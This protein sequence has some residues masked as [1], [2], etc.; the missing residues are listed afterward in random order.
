M[1]NDHKLKQDVL[2]ELAWE[3]SIS[4]DHIG[5]TAK[6]GVITLSGYVDNFW[7]KRSAEEA[8]G[9]V[10]G[11]KAIAEE[12]EVQ[13]PIHIKRTDNDIAAAAINRLDWNVLVPKDGVKVHVQKGYV[14]LT[15]TVD[16]RYQKVAAA[17]GIRSL[18]GVTG[19]ADQIATRLRPDTASI[20]SDITHALHRAHALD[21]SI[22][23]TA[24]GG[25]VKLTGKAASWTD[26]ELAGK[27]AWAAPGTSSVENDI[28]VN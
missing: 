17:D 15:G 7:Q 16:Y 8:A 3:P 21:Q 18:W 4:A 2:A 6:D 22:T 19:V 12:I 28:H 14:T 26:R 20:K 27:T 1:N 10:H 24:D 23:V 13:L 5:V 9:R 11:V 25:S